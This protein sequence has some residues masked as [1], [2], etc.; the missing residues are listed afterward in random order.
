MSSR[1]VSEKYP[2]PGTDAAA[3]AIYARRGTRGITPLDANLLNAPDIALGYSSLLEAIRTKG[4]LAGHIRE[5][6]ILRIAAL[7]HA[8]YEWTQHVDL[9][10]KEGLTT[11]QLYIIRDTDTPLLSPRSRLMDGMI[12]AALRFTDESTRE[13]KVEKEVCE[14]FKEE[15]GRLY[16]ERVDEVYVEA[17]MVVGTYN[18]VSRFLVSTDV[19]G[20]SDVEVPWPVERTEVG[21]FHEWFVLILTWV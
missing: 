7:N 9:G 17:A 19:G 10:R 16:G 18:M 20:M 3:D 21:Y 5:A 8:A 13:V 12:T 15:I 6:M 4:R 2:P 11:G 14:R 1:V